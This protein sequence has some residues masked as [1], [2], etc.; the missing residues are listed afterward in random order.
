MRK[1]QI[2]RKV[3]KDGKLYGAYLMVDRASA[4]LIDAHPIDPESKLSV[5]LRKDQVKELKMLI[6]DASIR[7][8]LNIVENDSAFYYH[9]PVQKYSA[10]VSVDHD[11]L[12]LKN[13]PTGTKIYFEECEIK[14]VLRTQYVKCEHRDKW[15]GF[16]KG[17]KKIQ[18]PTVRIHLGRMIHAI[19]KQ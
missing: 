10:A 9:E 1:G 11:I 6:L 5:T 2:V 17:I 18:V 13:N 19:V 7:D 15:G 12:V 3:T 16:V 14:R 8:I 4:K